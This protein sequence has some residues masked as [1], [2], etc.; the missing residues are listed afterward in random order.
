MA[1]EFKVGERVVYR[2]KFIKLSLTGTVYNP[3]DKKGKVAVKIDFGDIRGYARHLLERLPQEW[4]KREIETILV[5]WQKQKKVL[6]S[7]SKTEWR[8]LDE[9]WTGKAENKLT[10]IERA[11]LKS[12]I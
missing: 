10:Y 3:E 12:L 4:T 11:E 9:L 6:E 8:R 5:D 7:L 1:E 2:D